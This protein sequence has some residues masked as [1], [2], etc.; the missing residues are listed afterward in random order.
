MID[1]SH[2]A[3][4]PLK[5]VKDSKRKKSSLVDT[6]PHGSSSTVSS[7]SALI[8]KAEKSVR[9]NK[10]C[11][12]KKT[13]SRNAYTLQEIKKCWFSD[14]EYREIH[15]ECLE[16]IRK[17]DR[18]EEPSAIDKCRRGLDCR[19]QSAVT[20]RQQHRLDA[21]LIVLDEQY[22]GSSPEIIAEQYSV[23]SYR[24]QLWA[25][26]VGHRDKREAEAYY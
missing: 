5:N 9:F 6:M 2:E 13:I 11:Y 15:D 20:L 24:C 19:T 23:I 1:S 14:E 10:S 8:N 21:L 16:K 3:G 7:K 4:C 25:N 18:G 17:I 22:I 12:I 26:G